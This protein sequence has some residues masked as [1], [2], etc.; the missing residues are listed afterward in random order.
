MNNPLNFVDPL[1]LYCTYLN[2]EGSNVEGIDNNSN[3]GE[4]NENGGYWIAGSYGPGSQLSIDVDK[5]TVM[6]IGYDS[7]GN[8]EL[9]RAGASGSNG[10]GAWTQTWANSGSGLNWG[11]PPNWWGTFFADLND[12]KSYN[13]GQLHASEVGYYDCI[14]NK[15]IPFKGLL[16]A[17]GA[18]AVEEAATQGAEHGGGKLAGAYYHFTDGRFTA[19][20]NSSKVLV[21]SAAAK[22]AKVAKGASIAGWVLTDAELAEAIH[23]CSANLTGNKE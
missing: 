12:W 21:P 13:A 2:D 19:W 16:A 10:W 5:G 1:G 23:T 3:S 18:K 9:S 4:C 22:I 17:T 6:G 7:N 14:G 15:M 20:G 8:P 11:P